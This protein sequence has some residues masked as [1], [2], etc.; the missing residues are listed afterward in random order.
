MKRT[1][2]YLVCLCFVLSVCVVLQQR[3]LA[4][5]PPPTTITVQQTPPSSTSPAL[6]F[7][8][9]IG[10]SLPNFLELYNQSDEA[11]YLGAFEIRVGIHDVNTAGCGDISATI[12]LPSSWLLAKKYLTLE[13]TSSPAPDSLSYPFALD[14]LFL[15]TCL[16]PQLASLALV[17]GSDDPEQLVAIPAS[18]WSGVNLTVAQHKQR[19]N[20]PNSTRTIS[21]DFLTD[22]KIATGAITLNSDPLYEPPA[23]NAGL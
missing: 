13:R 5:T 1:M 10:S 7:T 15:S 22:Y 14:P 12:S 19:A 3:A 11:L 9:I 4:A 20:S 2:R 23:D 6:I 16:S 8:S 18:S 17:R 21:G